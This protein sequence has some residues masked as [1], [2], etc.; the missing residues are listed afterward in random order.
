WK[1]WG[2]MA[3]TAFAWATEVAGEVANLDYARRCADELVEIKTSNLSS[4]KHQIA[5]KIPLKSLYSVGHH[6]NP[7]QKQIFAQ[8][9]G[10]KV[11]EMVMK[12]LE[13]D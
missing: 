6:L 9:I 5:V 2:N 11:T 10:A 4:A 12:A 13:Q 1:R 3:E 8:V 7:A